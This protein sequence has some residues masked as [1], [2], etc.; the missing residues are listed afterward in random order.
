MW[1]AA[2]AYLDEG[3]VVLDRDPELKSQLASL[4]Y[5]YRDGVLLMQDKKE[6]KKQYGRSPD[7]A[8]AFVLTFAV[9][10]VRPATDEQ[11]ARRRFDS[12]R[13]SGA[14]GY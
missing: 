2:K 6:Y 10:D 13:P 14:Q 4:A 3:G 12:K 8:D 1:R 7:R 5:R 9:P 11:A